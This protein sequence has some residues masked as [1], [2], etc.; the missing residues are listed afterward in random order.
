V[1]LSWSPCSSSKQA[2]K[3]CLPSFPLLHPHRENSELIWHYSLSLFPGTHK[4]CP[5]RGSDFDH[6]WMQF[7]LFFF[8]LFIRYFLHLHFQCYPKSPQ[9]SPTPLPYPPTP[10]SWPW[11]SSVL[12]HTKF[13]QPMGLSFH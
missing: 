9:Y 7:Q 2:W 8:S 1:L 5:P 3:P 10:T 11:C 6:V 12:R 4:E 13:A